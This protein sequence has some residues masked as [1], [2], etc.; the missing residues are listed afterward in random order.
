MKEYERF[1]KEHGEALARLKKRYDLISNSRGLLALAF[2][3]AFYF[4]INN[5]EA[6]LM[7][8]MVVLV[9][10]FMIL[11]RI[12]DSISW[13]MEMKRTLIMINEEELAFLEKEELPFADGAE[14][15]DHAHAY[16]HDLDL[17]GKRSLF[18]Y[19][20]RTATYI[21]RSKFA[22]GLLT[23]L[24]AP[25][26]RAEQKAIQELSTKIMFRQ[27]L[28][29]LARIARDSREDYQNLMEWSGTKRSSIPVAVNL[30]AYASPI[31]L[32]ASLFSYAITGDELFVNVAGGLFL[33]NLAVF[34][35]QLKRI[36]QEMASS[37]RMHKAIKHYSLIIARI[38]EEDLQSERL[39]ELK[40]ELFNSS[41]TVSSHVKR[42]SALFSNMDSMHSG[43]GAIVFNGSLLY[44]IHNLRSLMK[45][46]AEFAVH[47]PVW[48]DVI[49]AFEALNSL[50][51]FAFNDPAF[52]YPEINDRYEIR[53]KDAGHPLIRAEKRVNN[54]VAFD[55]QR[56]I[57]LSGSNMAGKSTFLR[58][59]GVNMVMA[60]TGAPICASSANIHPLN[61]LVSMRS[62]DSL[63]EGESYFFAEVKRL[64]EIMDRADAQVS[65]V[66]LDEI[67]R[68]TNSD[69]KRSGTIEVI[70]KIIEKKAIGA[71]ATH[72]LEVCSTTAEYPGILA[73]QC[74]EVQVVNDELHF[75]YKL[76]ESI[77]QNKSA[78][79]LMK[80]MGII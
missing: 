70:R 27:D 33:F 25:R 57:I 66:L 22:T 10:G 64:R 37:D 54:D 26:I 73:N 46:K 77:S 36:K 47:I 44:H 6:L 1:K 65:F 9:I 16:S 55:Q 52:C 61:V 72:D 3:A 28:L 11:M 49:A 18:Q 5:S 59:L 53:M 35:S 2:A 56:F 41:A 39:K 15:I 30:L 17:F 7:V 14:F 58:T 75:D 29:A 43:I 67:L 24:P 80:K 8:A 69:D 60:G 51:N 40:A 31:L 38:E 13:Q 63:S 78:T 42:L 12:H 50:A 19:L 71:I 34:S 45:W 62:T 20:N 4:F 68:G 23:L 76:R 21:G 48:L 32:V 79:F 74:F